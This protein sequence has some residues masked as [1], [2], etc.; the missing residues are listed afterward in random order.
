MSRSSARISDPSLHD[1]LLDV[2]LISS[3]GPALQP[4]ASHSWEGG[5]VPAP[6][7]ASPIHRYMTRCFVSFSSQVRT[8]IATISIS[9]LGRRT[10]PRSSWRFC[11]HFHSNRFAILSRRVAVADSSPGPSPNNSSRLRRPVQNP[12]ASGHL[13]KRR[14]FPWR[15]E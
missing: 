15:A 4:S 7:R 9:Q 1:P 14:G 2:F 10:C 3:P 13:L 8:S 6:P 5:L 12:D 11:F